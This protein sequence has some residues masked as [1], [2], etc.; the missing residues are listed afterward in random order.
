LELS[1][2]LK[3]EASQTIESKRRI[4][5]GTGSAFLAI[6]DHLFEGMSANPWK[7]KRLLTIRKPINR[8]IIIQIQGRPIFFIIIS[9]KTTAINCRIVTSEKITKSN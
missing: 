2:D 9:D 8:A 5:N 3:R 4:F 7:E 1:R 6:D